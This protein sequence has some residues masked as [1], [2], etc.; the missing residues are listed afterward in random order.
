[1]QILLFILFNFEKLS[2]GQIF[3]NYWFNFILVFLFINLLNFLIE[4]VIIFI[5]KYGYFCIHIF[6]IYCHLNDSLGLHFI[7][8]RHF[9]CFYFF[10]FISYALY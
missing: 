4:Q 9:F 8:L 6:S 10:K 2:F 7:K 5:H 3:I 1:M